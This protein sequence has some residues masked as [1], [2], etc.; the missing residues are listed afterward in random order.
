M[1]FFSNLLCVEAAIFH[2]FQSR[3]K[4]ADSLFRGQAAVPVERDFDGLEFG[5]LRSDFFDLSRGD[6]YAISLLYL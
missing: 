1:E 6:I 5:E 3:D 4:S 2:P